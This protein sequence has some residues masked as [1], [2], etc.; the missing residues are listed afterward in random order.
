VDLEVVE[1][2][3]QTDAFITGSPSNVQEVTIPAGA[4]GLSNAV[5]LKNQLLAI[6]MPEEWTGYAVLTF[7][8]SSDGIAFK[9]VYDDYGYEV[10]VSAPQP[11]HIVCIDAAILK[12]AALR[13]IKIRSGTS[14]APVDQ[15]TDRT[16]KLI[17]KG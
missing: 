2:R 13:Y 3:L 16:L 7:Q 5:E 15:V 9:D 6:E 12:L 1:G 14:A 8:G 4:T 10:L 17:G 11:N